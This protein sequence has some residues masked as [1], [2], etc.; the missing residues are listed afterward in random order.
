[1]LKD[2]VL[3]NRSYRRFHQ[4]RRITEEQLRRWIEISHM[5]PSG[6][7][8]QPL[9]FRMVTG[10][11]ECGKVF[12]QLAWAGY[13]TDWAGPVEGERPSAYVVLLAKAGTN[14]AWDEGIV[15]QTLLLAAVEEGYGGCILANVKRDACKEALAIP[16]EYDI[17]LVIALGAPKEEVVLTTVSSEDSIKYYRDE[18]RTH[19]V[20]KI[21]VDEIIL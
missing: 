19:Y 2:L 18:N 5:T 8:V 20:P 16:Q 1:M 21:A 3:K 15:S 14:C 13:L 9:R 11:D 7:N 6:G 10:E 17:K 4:E 12:E